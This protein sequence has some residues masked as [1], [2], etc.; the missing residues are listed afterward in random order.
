MS[1]SRSLLPA[2]LGASAFLLLSPTV[3]LAQKTAEP[4]PAPTP[5]AVPPTPAPIKV[6]VA[7]LAMFE[8]GNPTGDTPGEFQ[9]WVEREKFDAILPLPAGH[10][11]VY[12]RTSDGVIGTVT[13]VATAQAAASVMA[14]G[15]DP[16]FDFSKTYW[17]IAGIAGVDPADA[18]TGSAAWAD[19]VVDGDLA[20]EIDAREIPKDWPTGFVPLN[21]DKPYPAQ[22]RKRTDTSATVIYPLNK[23]LTEWAYQLTKDVPLLDTETMQKGRARYTDPA[24]ANGRKPPF[25][26]KGDTLSSSTFWHGA[27]LNAWANDWVKYWSEGKAN[28]VTTAMEDTGSLEALTRLSKAGRVDLTR[29]MVLRTAS[30]YDRQ[31]P[32]MTAAENLADENAGNY[33]AYIPS[34][35][36][37]HRVGSKVV[38]ELVA[39]WDK[40]EAAPPR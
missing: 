35:E 22:R 18:S 10:Y 11:N 23:A 15:L 30:N 13:G 2:L 40:Y 7:I 39:N 36:A 28:Y 32:G 8:A 17:L 33:S 37:A 24:H 4:S 16:R 9:L 14:L 34:L 1:T 27:L 20:H 12:V 3:V 31:P 6:K 5:A 19:Y 21:D 25:V 26:L 38:R 29:V